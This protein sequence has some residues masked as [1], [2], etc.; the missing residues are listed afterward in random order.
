MQQQ[1]KK[2]NITA[3][4]FNLAPLLEGL[5][6]SDQNDDNDGHDGDGHSEKKRKPL[7]QQQEDGDMNSSEVE[8]TTNLGATDKYKVIK[9]HYR[10]FS[11]GEDGD[12]GYVEADHIP[13]LES[14][15][16]APEQQEFQSLRDINP[17]LYNM[18]LSLRD[19]KHGDN[20]PTVQVLTHHH[21]DALSTG[22]SRVSTEVRL[23]LARR[24]ARG[25]VQP[26]LKQ[27]FII[28]HPYASQQIRND[29]GVGSRQWLERLSISEDRTVR[30][31]TRAFH[32]LLRIY[33]NMGIIS[34]EQFALLTEYVDNHGY[35]DRDCDEYKEI[36]ETVRRHG[37]VA[38]TSP[39]PI[40]KMNAKARRRPR[41][42]L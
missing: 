20:L 8:S 12:K 25:Q 35:L 4:V 15:R 17:N 11:R 32:S 33:S 22:A 21:R 39:T 6:R 3:R 31:Y 27:A 24:I 18:V 10:D 29:A 36:L 41:E 7:Q 28:A 37:R 40:L 42:E 30:I 19:D 16:R 9:R 14:L 1:Q 23:L 38:Q 2:C 5:Q 26:M 34:A 13:P